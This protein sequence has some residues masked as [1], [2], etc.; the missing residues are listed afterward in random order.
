M[1]RKKA[2]TKKEK[3]VLKNT[4]FFNLDF[5]VEVAWIKQFRI[6]KWMKNL[7]TQVSRTLEKQSWR[8][9]YVREPFGPSM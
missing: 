2:L 1:D 8:S 4:K 5:K 6:G 7:G 3:T 9:K